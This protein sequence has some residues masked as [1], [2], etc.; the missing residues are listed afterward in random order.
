MNIELSNNLA[1]IESEKQGSVYVP[2]GGWRYFDG[3][4]ED[5][6]TLTVTG[7]YISCLT[8]Y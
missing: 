4:W 8:L 5:D 6:D 3:G 2:V 7:K 1:Y